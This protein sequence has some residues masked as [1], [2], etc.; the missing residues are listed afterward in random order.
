MLIICRNRE[1]TEDTKHCSTLVSEVEKFI[2][3]LYGER[4][5]LLPHA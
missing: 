3:H 1:A 5:D 2:E 4:Y